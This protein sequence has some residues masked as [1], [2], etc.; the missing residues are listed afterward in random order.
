MHAALCTT[1]RIKYDHVVRV[2]LAHDANPNCA[3]KESVETEAFMRDCRTKGETPLHRAAAFGTGE[4]IRLLLEAGA[5]RDSQD[6]NGDTPLAWASW[7]LRPATI[8]RQLCYG[9]FRIDPDY[10]EMRTNLTGWPHV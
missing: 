8:L 2:L 6:M 1:D 10:Q 7:Y 9:D 5:I 3:T 4:T